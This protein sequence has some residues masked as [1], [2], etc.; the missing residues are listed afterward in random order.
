[1]WGF[2]QGVKSGVYITKKLMSA[3]N[4]KDY[5]AVGFAGCWMEE[6]HCDPS[7]YNKAE[8]NGTFKGSSANGQGYGAGLAIR[9]CYKIMYKFIYKFIKKLYKC[10]GFY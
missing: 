2:A 3:L 4:L 7:A 6:S 8:K 1:M 9:Y 10:Y 5:Q